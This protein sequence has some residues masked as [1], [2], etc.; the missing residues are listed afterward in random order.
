MQFVID[1][2]PFIEEFSG[3]FPLLK[4]SG[5]EMDI[6]NVQGRVVKADIGAQTSAT[7]AASRA[8]V[9]VLI[10]LDWKACQDNVPVTAALVQPIFAER[11]MESQLLCDEP[12]LIFLT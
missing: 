4:E 12:G 2:D 1:D 3:L 10:T 7:L 8:N 5:S 9:V 6:E 11:E